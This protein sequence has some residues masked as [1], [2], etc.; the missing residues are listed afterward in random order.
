VQP[1]ASSD[2]QVQEKLP[3]RTRIASF[4]MARDVEHD[5]VYVF[6]LIPSNPYG[7]SFLSKFN[8]LNFV[9]RKKVFMEAGEVVSFDFDSARH[10]ALVEYSTEEEALNV[11]NFSL[12]YL[13]SC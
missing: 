8:F 3:K 6:R 11:T 5:Q 12:L 4:D 10:L 9:S 1:K 13:F 7:N 2:K